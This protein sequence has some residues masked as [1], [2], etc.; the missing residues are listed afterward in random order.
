MIHNTI[1]YVSNLLFY[2]ALILFLLLLPKSLYKLT[3]S[4]KLHLQGCHGSG[5]T[6]YWHADWLT[7]SGTPN[8]PSTTPRTMHH[9]LLQFLLI[10]P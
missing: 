2:V 5:P 7:M 4:H 9:H 1:I 3:V 8:H 10:R 6:N